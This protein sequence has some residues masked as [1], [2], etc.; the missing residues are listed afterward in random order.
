MSPKTLIWSPPPHHHPRSHSYTSF[1]PTHPCDTDVTQFMTWH[2]S[3]FHLRNIVLLCNTESEQVGGLKLWIFRSLR[4][5]Y[6]FFS[7]PCFFLLLL[8]RD[9]PN[10]PRNKSSKQRPCSVAEHREFGFWLRKKLRNTLSDSM[11]IFC[12]FCAHLTCLA[13]VSPQTHLPE[14]REASLPNATYKNIML[15]IHAIRERH[16]FLLAVVLKASP[17]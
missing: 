1:Y 3:H 5:E 11:L 9:D 7:R 2:L 17:C 6:M 13:R 15:Y 16:L 12:L 4:T 14:V 10:P 8:L